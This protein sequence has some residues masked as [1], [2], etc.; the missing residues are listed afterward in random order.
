MPLKWAQKLSEFWAVWQ[1]WLWGFVKQI[2]NSQV[3]IGDLE[4][5]PTWSPTYEIDFGHPVSV[6]PITWHY[7]QQSLPKL[8][9][10]GEN[11]FQKNNEKFFENPAKK[12]YY[13]VTKIASL[14]KSS[15]IAKRL[16]HFE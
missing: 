1:W 10:E 13:K 6:G 8:R 4:K 14:N 15:K 7:F 5:A 11:H 12:E 3:T 2:Y 16:R 9:K